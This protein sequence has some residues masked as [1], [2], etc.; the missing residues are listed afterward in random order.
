M[1]SFFTTLGDA[2]RL[3]L[4]VLLSLLMLGTALADE[5]DPPGRVARL[6]FVQGSVSLGPAGVEDWTAAELNRP[7]TTGDRLWTDAAGSRAELDI[8]GAVIRLGSGTGFSFLN[9]DDSTAQMQVTAGTVI[10]HLRELLDN[11]TYEIDTPNIALVLDQPGQYRVDV[12]ENGGATVVRVSDG[13]A[14]AT[15][16]AQTLPVYNQQMV[17]FTGT[18]QQLAAS[19]S[20][21][22]APDGLDDWSFERD[23]EY[24]DADSRRYVADDVAGAQD[25]DDNGEW[26]DTPDYGPVWIPTTVAVGWAPYSYGRWAWVAPWGWT[27]VDAAPWGFAP[28]HYGRWAQWRGSW[29]WVPGPR[30]V[31]P[32]YAPA[33]VAWVGGPRLG[34]PGAGGPVGWFPLGPRE[35][36]VPGY[37]VSDRYVRTINVTN[38]TIVNNTYITNVYQNRV[39]NIRYVNST[40]PGAVTTVPRSVFTSAQ[41]VNAHRMPL[42]PGELAHITASGAPPAITPV[43]QSYLGGANGGPVRRPPPVVS[44]RTVVARTPPPAA[45]AARVRMVAPPRQIQRG[46]TFNAQ[47]SATFDNRS[48]SDRAR[49]L[50]HNTTLPP[51][52]APG[53][54]NERPP[55]NG[56]AVNR[57]APPPA[58][59]GAGGNRFTPPPG[60]GAAVNRFAPPPAS[61]APQ[62]RP[63][64]PARD[65]RPGRTQ[66]GQDTNRFEPNRPPTNNFQRPAAADAPATRFSPPP[67]AP[68]PRAPEPQPPPAPVPHF[69]SPPP[70]PA[71]VPHVTPSPPP[72]PRAAPPQHAPAPNHPEASPRGQ[73]RAE[74]HR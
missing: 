12:D 51:G 18:G 14:E 19:G 46:P 54:R 62:N 32:V 9:L 59:G 37:R 15:A 17:T 40:V 2:K 20:S 3:A 43:R 61:P 69:N 26:Q 71:P 23:R 44:N 52:A 63:G 8:G 34:P 49:A 31:R 56:S 47:R 53:P 39:T 28:F 1:R 16:G 72:A 67:P 4:L 45:A 5:P 25:L 64:V 73:G 13:Q 42:A 35:V 24:E 70:P 60:N 65:D 55:A 27:W 57:F 6:S 11:Q 22:G 48:L 41:P 36:Y 74:P 33:M 30:N 68:V 58:N 10:V 29:C 50:E 66:S 38:T 21:L 7:L